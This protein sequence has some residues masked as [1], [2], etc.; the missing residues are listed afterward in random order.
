MPPNLSQHEQR[1]LGCLLEKEV[2]TP[3]VYPM[4]LNSLRLA[5]N[6]RTSREPV[7]DLDD[8]EVGA[9]LNTLKGRDL[10]AARMDARATKYL[11]S[12]AKV[13]AL[14]Q[15]ERAVLTLLLLRGPQT[16]GEL[17]GRAERLHSFNSPAEVEEPLLALAQRPDGAWVQRLPRRPGEKEAR[18]VHCLDGGAQAE[19]LAAGPVQGADP[20][21]PDTA[22]LLS[23]VERLE[24]DL[25]SLRRRFDQAGIGIGTGPPSSPDQT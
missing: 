18:W 25:A 17:R 3:E 8:S 10:A 13:A 11:H 16:S 6:Q 4:T 9:A 14:S 15:A 22:A 12:L 7:L 1:V 21:D 2:L 24:A 23:R 19:A 20:A 5:C